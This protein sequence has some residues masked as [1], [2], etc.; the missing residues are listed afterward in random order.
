MHLNP[1]LVQLIL[2]HLLLQTYP[3]LPLPPPPP[4]PP[5]P[6]PMILTPLLT[7]LTKPSSPNHYID[8]SLV[9]HI[10]HIMLIHTNIRWCSYDLLGVSSSSGERSN[11]RKSRYLRRIVSALSCR[12][13][14]VTS[15]SSS[16]GTP[17]V[18]SLERWS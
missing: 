16:R 18:G 11:C 7:P 12:A 17:G 2:L 9:Y 8:N 14:G 1:V 13:A 15:T 4:S 10:L 3:F 6:P 5:P